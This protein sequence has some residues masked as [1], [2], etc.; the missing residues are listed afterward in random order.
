MKVQ[1]PKR[2][3][4]IARE[5]QNYTSS[6]R[7]PLCENCEHYTSM[8]IDTKWGNKEEKKR[9]CGI[10]EFAVKRKATCS[11]HVYCTINETDA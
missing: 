7:L 11:A 3:Q 5:Q 8:Y 6:P 4:Q 1:Q 10:G 2:K 9:R